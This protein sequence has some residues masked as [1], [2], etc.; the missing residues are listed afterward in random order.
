VRH[1]TL[2]TRLN[3]PTGSPR[4]GSAGERALRD[5]FHERFAGWEMHVDGGANH[6]RAASNLGHAR[7]LV[8]AEGVDG[9]VEDAR[10]AAFGVR[11]PTRRSRVGALM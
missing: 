3:A 6:A 10:D 4:S 11:A 1:V 8:L 9:G 2:T 5:G 7:L